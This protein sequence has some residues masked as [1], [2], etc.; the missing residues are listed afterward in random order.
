MTATSST[1]EAMTDTDGEDDAFR[2]WLTERVAAYLEC[3][4]SAVDPGR[5]LAEYGLDSV[6]ALTLCGEIEDFLD[7]RLEPTVVWD[8]STID[9]LLAELRPIA[10][11]R[12]GAP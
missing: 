9:G 8:C 5:P 12:R 10:A 11:G 2:R 6:L 4:P 1:G 3:E 7:V